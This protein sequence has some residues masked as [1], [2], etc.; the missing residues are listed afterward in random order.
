MFC[1]LL[2]NWNLDY[3]RIV[4]VCFVCLIIKGKWLILK[5]Y[6]NCDFLFGFVDYLFV[7]I[8]GIMYFNWNKGVLVLIVLK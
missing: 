8:S 3:V 7:D 2:F 1:Y 4:I 5:I 6:V